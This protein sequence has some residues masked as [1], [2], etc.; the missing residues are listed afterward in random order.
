MIKTKLT[1]SRLGNNTALKL[2]AI[3]GLMISATGCVQK[4][5]PEMR[6]YVEPPLSKWKPVG[7]RDVRER[8]PVLGRYVDVW[9]ERHGNALNSDEITSVIAP[10]FDLACVTNPSHYFAVAGA[11]DSEGFYYGSPSWAADKSIINK[12]NTK[13]CTT[14]WALTADEEDIL[15]IADAP[16]T[17]I[18]PDTGEEFVLAG[19]RHK[20]WLLRKDGS[21][22]WSKETR[23]GMPPNTINSDNLGEHIAWGPNYLPGADGVIMITGDGFIEILDR[24]TGNPL[25]E[26]PFKMAG[27]KAPLGQSL[28]PQILQSTMQKKFAPFIA[29]GPQG[30]TLEHVGAFIL[31]QGVVNANTFSRSALPNEGGRIFIS[32]T[33]PDEEDGTVDGVSERGAVYTLDVLF[34]ADS[35]FYEIHDVCH[36][37]FEGGSGTT[38]AGKADA[39]RFYVGDSSGH[40]LAYDPNNCQEIWRY[41]IGEQI[42]ASPTVSSDNNELYVNTQN[43][44]IALIDRD[45]YAE[46]KYSVQFDLW[47]EENEDQF[48]ESTFLSSPIS[49][50]H[51]AFQAGISPKLPFGNGINVPVKLAVGIADRETGEVL[52][53]SEAMEDSTALLQ[54]LND[55]SMVIPQAP[56]RSLAARV[57]LPLFGFAQSDIAQRPVRGGIAVWRSTRNDLVIR[58]ASCAAF[59]R[60][61]RATTIYEENPR[62]TVEDL[63]AVEDLIKQSRKV[64]LEGIEQGVLSEGDWTFINNRFTEV[65]SLHNAWLQEPSE[66]LLRA[67]TEEL[68]EA[69]SRL[70]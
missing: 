32:T 61:S 59:D 67:A 19:K 34:N 26:Q 44:L 31:G 24:K 29:G 12:F 42:V 11:Q 20:V 35:G 47:D 53:V 39:S 23:L 66:T 30:A 3:M 18:D 28:I 63:A 6:Q 55:G 22:V 14:E 16:M 15:S 5:E 57:L 25:I 51:L 62:G 64:A 46:V 45:S 36:L 50:N 4:P 54:P 41:N 48:T 43:D 70:M 49:A 52:W 2:I 38:T 68:S 40:L 27:S 65:E 33:A 58:D 17:I 69:C 1:Q 13:D 60:E 10:V 37:S 9:N 8:D 21:V 7:T 56:S